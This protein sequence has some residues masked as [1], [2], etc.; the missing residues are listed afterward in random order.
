MEIGMACGVEVNEEMRS[1]LSLPSG[2]KDQHDPIA[3]S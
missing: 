3:V 1:Q 2:C